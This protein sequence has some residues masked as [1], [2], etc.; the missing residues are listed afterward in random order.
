MECTA[1][2]NCKSPELKTLLNVG[3]TVIGRITCIL[4]T[5]KDDDCIEEEIILQGLPKDVLFILLFFIIYIIYIIFITGFLILN[6]LAGDLLIT[7]GD[8]ILLQ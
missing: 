1:G 3:L 4:L 8:L 5:S 7:A 6:S 2:G